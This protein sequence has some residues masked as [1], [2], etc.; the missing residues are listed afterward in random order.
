MR[1][2]VLM[3]ANAGRPDIRD[4]TRERFDMIARCVNAA[5]WLSN[6][7]RNDVRIHIY[8][9]KMGKVVSF[10][11]SIKRVSPDERSIVLWID[12]VLKGIRNPGID[13]VDI[14]FEDFLKGMKNRHVYLL[15]E[16][17]KDM[18]KAEIKADPVFVIGD[19]KGLEDDYLEILKKYC[20]G[21][22]SLGRLSYL[23]SHCIS[24]L[25]MWLD[26]KSVTGK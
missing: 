1:E 14:S 24:F 19:H 21:T 9:G 26:R 16:E 13:A 6:G 20:P 7:I 12:K 10:S 18:E 2:F 5:F 23:S 11:S 8:L 4:V 15:L 25:N 3:A 17:G 22:I